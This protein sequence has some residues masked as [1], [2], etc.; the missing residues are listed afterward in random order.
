[1]GDDV[2]QLSVAQPRD[3]V[4]PVLAKRVDERGPLDRRRSDGGDGVIVVAT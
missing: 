4:D 1:L 3:A 2:G